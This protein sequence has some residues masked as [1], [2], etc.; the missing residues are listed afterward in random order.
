MA[1][2]QVT[3]VM[4]L[5]NP[6][7]FLNPFQFQITFESIE[8]LDDDLE[9]KIIYVGSAESEDQDQ[10][11]DSVLVGPITAGQHMFVFQANAPDPELIPSAD[12]LGVTVVLLTCSF[13]HKEFVRVGYYLNNEYLDPEMRENPPAAV[14]V[15]EI[16]R[17][18]L[19]SN[20]RVTRF[21]INWDE[22]PCKAAAGACGGNG[23]GCGMPVVVSDEQLLNGEDTR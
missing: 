13:R 14:N 17:N 4:V 16:Q 18:I 20:P 1:K 3:N 5:D 8:N 7:P 6:S 9:W 10:V 19:T 21:K 15:Q 22:Q 12:L 11:L 2:V 23:N